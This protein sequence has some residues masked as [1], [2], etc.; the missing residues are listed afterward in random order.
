M[1]DDARPLVGLDPDS[2][3]ALVTQI[4]GTAAERIYQA[5]Q[6]G[7]AVARAWIYQ[8]P[9]QVREMGE[10]QAPYY[11]GWVDPDGK[12]CSKSCGPGREGR[13]NAQKVKRKTEAELLTGTY[14]KKVG[15]TW[16]EFLDQYEEQALAT[17][18]PRTR[19]EARTALAHFHR[20][21]GTRKPAA[22]RTASIDQYKA[23]RLKEEGLKEGTTV[24]H[25]TV[26][27]ELRHL[28]A[29]LKK[30]RKWGYLAELPDIDFL[31]ELGKL[32]CYVPPEH[33]SK[34]YAACETAHLPSGLACSPADWWRALLVLIYL[35]G[36]RIEQVTLLQRD[37][38]N[39]DTGEVY[40]NAEDNKGG[41]D[42]KL[43]LHQVVLDHLR[44]VA[45]FEPLLF[46]WRHRR[47][48]L[49]DEF[50]RIQ[51][52]ASVKPDRKRHYGFHDLRRAFAT[53]NADRMTADALQRLMQH[54]D[55]KTTQKYLNLARQLRPA[56]E[57]LF[58]PELPKAK[59]A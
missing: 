50:K 25:A 4:V 31:R 36:W 12:R 5:N 11:V 15:G 27:K 35:T 41:R 21:T 34:L 55:Y 17:V 14:G 8:R 7:L 26:N 29:A 24:S 48:T 53:M 54:K 51:D 18:A 20:L 49:W 10:S 2:L 47:M 16:E 32:P 3:E 57:N 38:L 22:I 39:L 37:D 9:E 13:R 23:D 6:G 45:S 42:V 58:V 40:S 1:S 46:P 19:S 52:L 43:V 56:A 59:G 33:F 28:K 30:A 44:N